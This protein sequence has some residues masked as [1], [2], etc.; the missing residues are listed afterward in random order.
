MQKRIKMLSAAFVISALR[1][2]VNALTAK[3]EHSILMHLP[4]FLKGDHFS[5]KE[6]ESQ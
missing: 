3:R 5:R 6:G 1:V 4:P 2:K